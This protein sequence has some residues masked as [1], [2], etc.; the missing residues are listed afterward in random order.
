MARDQFSDFRAVRAT[1]PDRG[2]NQHV[3]AI[4]QALPAWARHASVSGRDSGIVI[5]LDDECSA[6]RAKVVALE[7]YLTTVSTVSLT[8]ERTMRYTH[9]YGLV[10]GVVGTDVDLKLKLD[11]T[12]PVVYVIVPRALFPPSED[13]RA[14]IE[15]AC[16]IRTCLVL[17]NPP[18][19]PCVLLPP[20]SDT[21]PQA[22]I[23][24][25]H[26]RSLQRQLT[27]IVPSGWRA[28]IAVTSTD[29]V[30]A[31]GGILQSRQ[32]EDRVRRALENLTGLPVRI[33]PRVLQDNL[34]DA[35]L[36]TV[37]E[38]IEVWRTSF[39]KVNLRRE[40]YRCAVVQLHIP[41]GREPDALAWRLAIEER[42][43]VQLLLQPQRISFALNHQLATVADQTGLIRSPEPVRRLKANLHGR[44]PTV[45][46]QVITAS[47]LGPVMDLRAIPLVTI[48]GPDTPDPEDALFAERCADGS[49]RLV[50][51]FADA[52]RAVPPTS[53]F[54]QYARRMASTFYYGDATIPMLGAE[55]TFRELPLTP[56][57]E[58]LAWAVEM[59]INPRGRIVRYDFCRALVKVTA[60]YPFVDQTSAPDPSEPQSEPMWAALEAVASLLERRGE[61]YH[62]LLTAESETPRTRIVSACMV[63]ARERIAHFFVERGIAVPFRVHGPPGRRQ[64]RH[65]VAAAR[66]IGVQ[67]DP[68]DFVEPKRFAQLLNR[69]DEN[70]AGRHLFH[71]I[72]DAHL[73]RA[74]FSRHRGPHI[75]AKCEQ[76]TEIKALRSYAG[77]LTQ[78]QAD[79]YFVYGRPLF[80]ASAMDREV[81]HL[82]RKAR[83]FSQNLHRLAM[84]HRIEERLAA[85]R[86]PLEAL[87]EENHAGEPLLYVPELTIVGTP[88]GFT[89][90]ELRPGNRL[91][92]MLA[93]YHVRSGGYA[94]TRFAPDRP[95]MS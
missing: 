62:G 63:S 50:V 31:Y 11:R 30:V 34:H 35:L 5:T 89:S 15:A 41:P 59:V 3:A 74:R 81:R 44:A 68:L 7:Q 48:D 42:F 66:A 94:F 25:A 73:S 58:R 2:P 76:Y 78:W 9:I 69:L 18:Y 33:E 43:G 23:E 93:G 24:Q 67:A 65:F 70:P 86:G 27:A 12:A 28:T 8:I 84:L 40:H 61:R 39:F 77:L 49:Y 36:T 80:S 56:G 26:Q 57:H 64:R 46:R 52:S 20:P 13:L 87:V 4:R 79:H 37:P 72:L 91:T 38:G 45:D 14:R 29:V 47:P 6:S 54:G 60:A 92:V 1:E 16:G 82:N 83:G 71:E 19:R 55:L 32:A 90:D 75:G 22:K 85:P 53:K 17:S 51:A 88:L 21:A 10:E 95:P